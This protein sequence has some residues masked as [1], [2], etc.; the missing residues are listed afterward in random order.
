MEGGI[1]K[2][3]EVRGGQKGTRTYTHTYPGGWV[4]VG[5]SWAYMDGVGEVVLCVCVC[6]FPNV[7]SRCFVCIKFACL[8]YV[9]NCI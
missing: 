3:E 5:D 1:K 2:E 4:V 7:S 8:L 9:S 6:V